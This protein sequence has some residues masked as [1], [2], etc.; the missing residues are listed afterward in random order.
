MTDAQMKPV[1]VRA[2]RYADLPQMKELYR[3]LSPEDPEP[4]SERA[5]ATW[6]Q[7]L[8]SDTITILVAERDERILASC[9]L[10]IVPNLTRGVRPFAVIENVV[11]RSGHRR[12]GLG[13]AVIAEAVGRAERA[14]CYKVMLATGRKDEGVLRFYEAVGFTRGGKTFFEIRML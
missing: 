7:L 11:T 3:D 8:R 14:G 2:A 9:L 13:R 5:A 12:C 1:A 4:D 10:M 6:T